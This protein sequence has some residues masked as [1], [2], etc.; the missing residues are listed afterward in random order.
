LKLAGFR[1]RRK[2]CV[3]VVW[4]Q[5]VIDLN[6]AY[7]FLRKRARSPKKM[8]PIQDIKSF[9]AQGPA[10][11]RIARRA[12]NLVKGIM[13]GERRV[14]PA[15]K[16]L[17]TD[18]NKVRLLPPIS[19]PPKILCLARNYVSH[20][21]EVAGDAPLPRSLLV[22]IKPTTSIIGPGDS[23]VVPPSCQ[24]LDYEVEL[25]VVIGKRGRYI[26][27]GKAMDHVA[28]YTIINDISDRE[29]I[30]QEETQRVNWFF[31]KAQDTFAPLGP[32]LVLK[33]EIQDPHL[34]RL[35]LWVNGELRQDSTGEDMIFMIPEIISQ[36]SHFVTLEPGDI[37]ATGTPTGTSFSTK[38][39]LKAGDVV[40]C[41]I[42]EIGRL[43]NFIKVEKPVYRKK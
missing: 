28:G 15:I 4:G 9:L 21:R 42:E 12:E 11:I 27:S 1:R 22:F 14:P 8:P 37:I 10:A 41:E 32:Y 25:A 39:Y 40:E 36:I 43:K 16:G 13:E 30:V 17:V 19:N 3:G 38:Q 20:A 5:K 35:R 18:L 34:L 24:K 29:Y 23:V 6:G 31:M 26:P 2:T 7:P 33:D